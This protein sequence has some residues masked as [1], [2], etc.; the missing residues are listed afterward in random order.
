MIIGPIL[1]KEILRDKTKIEL[2]DAASK[3]SEVLTCLYEFPL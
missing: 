3:E 1:T 2:N